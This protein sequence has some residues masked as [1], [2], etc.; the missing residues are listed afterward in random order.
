MA[1]K[2]TAQQITQVFSTLLFG[3]PSTLTYQSTTDAIPFVVSYLQQ[4]GIQSDAY[5]TLNN[6]E[7]VLQQYSQNL[8]LIN[9]KLTAL[10]TMFQTNVAQSQ[11]IA[12]NSLTSQINELANQ[13][14]TLVIN[15]STLQAK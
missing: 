11:Q 13:V 14:S 9:I 3:Q 2:P 1:F 15:V 10:T 12:I 7:R 6:H 4:R 8:S 5:A